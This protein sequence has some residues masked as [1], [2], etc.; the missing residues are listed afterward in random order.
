MRGQRGDHSAGRRASADHCREGAAVDFVKD[1]LSE[2]VSLAVGGAG[3][4]LNYLIDR[5]AGDPAPDTCSTGGVT[6]AT[7]TLQPANNLV[8]ELT[9]IAGLVRFF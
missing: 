3:A 4:A 5:F 2:H 9:A 7:A 8:T 6:V 1:E